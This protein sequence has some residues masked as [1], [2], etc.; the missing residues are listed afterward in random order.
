MEQPVRLD[1]RSGAETM[2]P[3]EHDFYRRQMVLPFVGEAGQER[4]RGAKVLVVGAGGLG[5]PALQYLAAAGV[6]TIT[7]CDP[8]PVEASNLHR[9]ILF[10]PADAGRPKSEVAAERLRAQNPF[11]NVRAVT[12]AAAPGNVAGL[13]AGQNVV[14]DCTDNFRAKFLLHDACW[15]AGIPLVQAAIYQTEGWLQVFRREAGAGCQRCTYPDIPEE[16]CTGTCAQVGVLG[17]VPGV[18]GTMQ[19]S[20]TL[21]LLL[22]QDG[23]ADQGL[24][25]LDLQSMLFTAISRGRN[26]SC[27]LCGDAPRITGITAGEYTS[28]PAWV[29]D[30]EKLGTTGLAGY[31]LVDVRTPAE[32][33]NGPSSALGLPNYCST[34]PAALLD[35]P[36]GRPYLLVCA[37]GMRSRNAAA[38]L[39]RQGRD[40]FFS[41]RQG[42]DALPAPGEVNPPLPELHQGELDEP[43]L[44]QL[45]QDLEHH[46]EVLSVN[47]KSTSTATAGRERLSTADG[48]ALLLHRAGTALQVRY[49]HDG[50]EWIDTLMERPAGWRIVRMR[51]GHAAPPASPT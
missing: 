35:L 40:D 5:C 7:I 32:H 50:A 10:T 30:L 16:G 19:A 23:V 1:R 41:L 9:Q 18:L 20:E 13:L 8:D 14:L 29:L 25:M 51:T 36:R 4:L 49:R 2:T 24:I 46:A 37:R 44:R 48:L 45:F 11:I 26:S 28:D 6:G 33:Q 47:A 21:K 34:N 17:V 31:T 27:P 3:L 22:G 42:V 15:L 39:R 12:A 38:E 43:G